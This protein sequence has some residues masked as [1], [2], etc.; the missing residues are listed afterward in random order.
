MV[1]RRLG[2]QLSAAAVLVK[3]G[4]RDA[5]AGSDMANQ[6]RGFPFAGEQFQRPHGVARGDGDYH[7]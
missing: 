5:L 2:A 1:P 6:L 3:R 4:V 7:P